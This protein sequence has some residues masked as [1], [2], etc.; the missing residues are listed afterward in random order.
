MTPPV[1]PLTVF[2]GDTGHW[3]ICL[4]L[5]RG[6]TIPVDLNDVLVAAFIEERPLLVEVE[7]PN[8]IQ[9]TLPAFVSDT[10]P[11][12]SRWTLRLKRDNGDVQTICRGPVRVV[13]NA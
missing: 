3:R 13:V 11:P 6:K 2:Q 8:V 1:Y 10:L 12:M 7:L 4:W 5:D 9:L